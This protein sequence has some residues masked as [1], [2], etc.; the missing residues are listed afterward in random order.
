MFICFDSV[1]V[2]QTESQ[3]NEKYVERLRS[4][5]YSNSDKR[6][7][8]QVIEDRKMKCCVPL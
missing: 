7:K 6:M 8:Q 3:R 2:R 1:T 4:S 5:P